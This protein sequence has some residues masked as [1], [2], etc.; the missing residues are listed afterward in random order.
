[1]TNPFGVLRTVKH[2]LQNNE[3]LLLTV[4]HSGH[5]LFLRFFFS[6]SNVTLKKPFSTLTK[7]RW[8]LA[9]SS[10]RFPVSL[11]RQRI[12]KAR[13]LKNSS[14]SSLAISKVS[15]NSSGEMT[16][17]RFTRESLFLTRVITIL[18]KNKTEKDG[19]ISER[20]PQTVENT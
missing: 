4:L 13:S 11:R 14:S 1:M 3:D 5:V 9:I 15:L 2:F 17:L 16:V 8:T 12:A 20:N 7:S 18:P 19:K 10:L 6:S